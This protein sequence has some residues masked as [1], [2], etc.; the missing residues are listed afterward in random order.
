MM[1]TMM[2]KMTTLVMVMSF[3]EMTT[4]GVG[5]WVGGMPF[6]ILFLFLFQEKNKGDVHLCMCVFE[7]ENG[8]KK[9]MC[10]ECVCVGC[11]K[12]FF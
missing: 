4:L 6:F 8:E 7:R 1:T 10:V 11:G 2:M 9:R 3:G 12:V 5:V